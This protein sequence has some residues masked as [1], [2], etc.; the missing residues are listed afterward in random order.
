MLMNKEEI[1]QGILYLLDTPLA[2]GNVE[3]CTGQ[4]I[5]EFLKI[6]NIVDHSEDNENSWRRL[7]DL[8]REMAEEGLIEEKHPESTTSTEEKILYAI[9]DEGIAAITEEKRSDLVQKWK[10]P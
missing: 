9:E 5:K 6:N 8:L 4:Q 1:K 2:G 7:K 3:G 10:L